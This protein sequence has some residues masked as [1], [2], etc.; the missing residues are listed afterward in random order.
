[1]A[2]LRR[3]GDDHEL[4]LRVQ[5]LPMAFHVGFGAG[6]GLIRDYAGLSAL[7]LPRYADLVPVLVDHGIWVAPRGIWYVSAAHGDSE[8][9]AVL[10]RFDAALTEA[11]RG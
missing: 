11:A 2:G 10:E 4:P 8:L 6:D 9:T 1:M 7:D 5:G 3:L